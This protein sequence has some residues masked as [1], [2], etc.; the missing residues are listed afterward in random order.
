[1]M[2][3]LNWRDI[4]FISGARIEREVRNYYIDPDLNQQSL[5]EFLNRIHL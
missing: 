1:M 3:T 5:A 4:E 2:G